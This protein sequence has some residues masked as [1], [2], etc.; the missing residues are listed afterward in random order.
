[1]AA[2]LA[3]FAVTLIVNALASAVVARSRSGQA[4]EI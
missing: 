3:L 2:G 4:T 1:M